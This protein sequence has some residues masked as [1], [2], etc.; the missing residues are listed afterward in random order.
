MPRYYRFSSY[1]VWIQFLVRG[2]KSE[3]W[4]LHLK[5]L[6]VTFSG[7][8]VALPSQ[9][10]CSVHIFLAWCLVPVTCVFSEALDA[11]C[12]HCKVLLTLDSN[13]NLSLSL[14]PTVRWNSHGQIRDLVTPERAPTI[15]IVLPML[16]L[17]IQL[18]Y[19]G[20]LVG[21][22]LRGHFYRIMGNLQVA[23]PL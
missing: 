20:S 1:P 18:S 17:R 3:I 23:T 8:I 16:N 14:K 2:R 10:C 12:L 11:R 15:E 22:Q 21:T 19:L 6:Y 4:C 5:G 9:V 7:Q 13:V